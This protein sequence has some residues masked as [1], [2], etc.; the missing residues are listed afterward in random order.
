MGASYEISR[1]EGILGGPEKPISDLGK[2]GYR[3]FWA[4]EIARW[5]LSLDTTSDKRQQETLIDVSDCSQ[6]TWISLEDCLSV[7]QD[8]GII[9]EAG[10]GPGKPEPTPEGATTSEESKAGEHQNPGNEEPAHMVP[11]LRID[12]RAVRRYVSEHRISLERT[13]DPTGFVEGYAYK[14][15]SSD[16]GQ[17]QQEEEEDEEI[18]N[19]G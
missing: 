9:E 16:A 12:K 2:K 11:R 17:H 15:E 1:R 8:M 7:L 5:L 14:V 18:E 4:G 6:A 13:C 10:L 3:R 19:S